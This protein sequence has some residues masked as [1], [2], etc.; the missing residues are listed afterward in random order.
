MASFHILSCP[1]SPSYENSSI[2]VPFFAGHNQ[3]TS[4]IRS[5]FLHVSHSLHHVVSFQMLFSLSCGDFMVVK[6]EAVKH[7]CWTLSREFSSLVVCF[8][9]SECSETCTPAFDRD[10]ESCRTLRDRPRK[11]NLTCH[12]STIRMM[13]SST[14]GSGARGCVM[15]CVG[16]ADVP[17]A[18]GTSRCA[19]ETRANFGTSPRTH[20]KTGTNRK[21]RSFQ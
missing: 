7:S 15:A 1:F 10:L 21:E 8:L 3:S 16:T 19:M 14:H 12:R 13:V 9:Q 20:S 18:S 6:T 17:A 2:L 11:K 4:C 5:R